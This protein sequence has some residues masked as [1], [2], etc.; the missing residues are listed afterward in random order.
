MAFAWLGDFKWGDVFPCL[1][2][3]VTG[4]VIGVVIAHAMFDPSLVAF[5]T[6]VQQGIPNW[7]AETVATLGLRATILGGIRLNA[8]R[9]QWLVGPYLTAA[10]WFTASTS[11]G[12]PAV[13]IARSSGLYLRS[14]DWRSACARC[15]PDCF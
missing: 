12:N 1:V 3:K 7:F 6:K 5:S 4:G 10:Y 13:V 14:N 11:F 8:A 9:V 2:A 15:C